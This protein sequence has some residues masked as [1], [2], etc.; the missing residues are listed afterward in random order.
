LG[1]VADEKS[2]GAAWEAD[3]KVEGNNV[4]IGLGETIKEKRKNGLRT[5]RGG[6]NEYDDRQDLTLKSAVPK[7]LTKRMGRKVWGC[8]S[9]KPKKKGN[10][11]TSS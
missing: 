9:S 8:L 4:P 7:K 1:N 6:E 10:P 2:S 5:E 3:S 11:G